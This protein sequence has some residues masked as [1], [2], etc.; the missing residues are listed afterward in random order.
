MEGVRIRVVRPRR[1]SVRS[2]GKEYQYYAVKLSITVDDDVVEE[3]GDEFVVFEDKELGVVRM[4]PVKCTCDTLTQDEI[5]M[6]IGAIKLLIER[7]KA[8]RIKGDPKKLMKMLMECLTSE[9]QDGLPEMSSS[10]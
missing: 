8:D 10:P 2:N 3:C 4:W 6:M 7:G 5:I 9:A 1:M